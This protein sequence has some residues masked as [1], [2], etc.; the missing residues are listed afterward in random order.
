MLRTAVNGIW[1]EAARAVFINGGGLRLARWKNRN[2][3]RILMYHRFPDVAGLEWQCRHLSQ[4]YHVMPFSEAAARLA[5]EGDLPPNAVVVTV[6]DGYRDFYDVAYPIFTDYKIPATVYV[7]TDFLDGKLWLWTDQVR[8]AF[9]KTQRSTLRLELP[10]TRVLEFLL[11]S[12]EERRAASHK[13][14]EVLKLLRN[15]DRLGVLAL[16]PV[17]LAVTLPSE[18]PADFQPLRWEDL[19]R[20]AASG[21]EVGAHTRTHPILSRVTSTAELRDEIVGS[22]RRIEEVLGMPV[23]HFCYPNGLRRDI[24]PEVAEAVREAGYEAAVTTEPGMNLRPAGLL[25]LRR[26]G[27]DPTY[28]PRY[29]EQCAAAFHIGNKLDKEASVEATLPPGSVRIR[30]SFSC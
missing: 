5:G 23:R 18:P 13:T 4:C 20:M 14:T 16:L 30:R 9:E 10:G 17:L 1:K 7:V 25:R 6:D 21:V 29:F 8:Y 19:R 11:R 15:E 27:V 2:G 24:G 22:K 12:P 28:E 3:L 26:I